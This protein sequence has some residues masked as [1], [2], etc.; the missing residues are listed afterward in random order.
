M[1]SNLLRRKKIDSYYEPIHSV[2]DK[3][4]GIIDIGSNSI[5]LVVYDAAARL[6]VPVF[7]EKAICQLGKGLGKTGQ[8]NKKGVRLAMQTLERFTYLA[9]EMD[10]GGL[11]FLATAAI[12]EASDGLTFINDVTKK[13]SFSVDVLSGNEEAR[14]SAMGILTATPLA[15]G[16]SGDLGGG[17]LDL[18]SLNRGVFGTSVSLSLGHLRLA[19]DSDF[20]IKRAETII[21]G[22]L[23]SN[24]WLSEK[25]GRTIYAIGGAWRGI[26]RLYIKQT[27]Y[28]LRVLDN[29]N[30]SKEEAISF[31]K[32]LSSQSSVSLQKMDDLASRRAETLPFAA[33]TLQKLIEVIEPQQ[34]IFSGYGLREGKFLEMLPEEM[35]KK[36]PLI[37]ACEGFAV[38]SG[39]FSIHGE[40]IATWI[41]PLFGNESRRFK[42]L[43]FAAALLSD[44]GWTEHPDYRAL[45]SFVRVLRLPFSGITHRQRIMLA[46]A[47][48]VRYGGKKRHTELERVKNLI[49]ESDKNRATVLGLAL[50]FSHVLSGGAPGILSSA[51]MVLTKKKL[52]LCV[53]NSR[54]GLVGVAVKDLFFELSKAVDA[55]AEIKFQK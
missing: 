23:A 25:P 41:E 11:V 45:H 10:I 5:R 37:S 13:F 30:I 39:R 53:D 4:I 35:K 54:R 14:L 43:S 36:D 55:R 42:H 9:G 6:P 28:P 52:E 24:P 31:T 48:Y 17:S 49:A 15:D 20:N 1:V 18:I 47:I 32:L 40:E 44:I 12:R 2:K 22:H 8:L 27:K 3:R 50:R 34:I 26:A 33:L 51:K 29:F 7:N 46:L 19:E 21:E 38:R 16:I